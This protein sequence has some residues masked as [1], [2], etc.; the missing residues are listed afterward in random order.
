MPDE[1]PQSSA[2]AAP[3]AFTPD[4]AQA[5]I[6]RLRSDQ[7][8]VRELTSPYLVVSHPAAVK[9]WDELH[10]LAAPSKNGAGVSP[11]AAPSPAD[12]SAAATP[13]QARSEIERLRTD[14]Q[15]VA[16]YTSGD[17]AALEQMNRLQEQGAAPRDGGGA[18]SASKAAATEDSIR[19]PATPDLYTFQPPA[20][21]DT[22]LEAEARQLMHGMGLPQPVAAYA[23]DA[24]NR[25]AQN[26]QDELSRSVAHANAE[27]Q[28][29]AAWGDK[30]EQQV[31]A[32]RS[33][34][35]ALPASQR[36]R[37]LELLDCTGLGD[38]PILIKQLAT[39]AGARRSLQR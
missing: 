19:A 10:R 9:K 11:A 14:P 35:D 38:D 25:A 3:P 12:R 13:E 20:D 16:R 23:Y 24:W 6:S 1:S 28:L 17:K 36:S 33:V 22:E 8:F 2:P 39:I 4:Q 27:S 21:V 18:L 26:P 31:S 5:E 29:R 30:Y 15:F 32:A 7:Q 34:I 37:A